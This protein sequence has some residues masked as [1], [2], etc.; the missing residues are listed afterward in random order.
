MKII[1]ATAIALFLSAGLATASVPGATITETTIVSNSKNNFSVRGGA[2]FVFGQSDEYVF[3]TKDRNKKESELNWTVD[4]L[5]M[6]GVGATCTYNY[7]F[8]VNVD[9]WF[10]ATEGSGNMDD[11]DWRSMDPSGNGYWSDHSWHDSEITDASMVDINLETVA[12]KTEDMTFSGIVGYKRDYFRWDATGDSYI[13]SEN[14][15]FRNEVGTYPDGWK[16]VSYEQIFESVYFGIGTT[17]QAGPVAI[18]GRIIYSPFVEG[19][20]IDKH[21]FSM[22]SSDEIDNGDMYGFDVSATYALSDTLGLELTYHYQNY[23]REQGDST[24]SWEDGYTKEYTNKIGMEHYSSL[25][26]VGLQYTF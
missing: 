6:V 4:S 16:T 2:G 8:K 22:G 11:Y 10:K 14:G 19:E 9:G 5:L 24:Y 12:Y 15:G 21:W 26:S 1:I 7:R 20:A 3:K 25:V 23:S 13:Y 18:A 17:Y